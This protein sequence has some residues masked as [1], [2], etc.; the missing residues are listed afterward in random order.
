ML[1][2]VEDL[3]VGDEIIVPSGSSL[4]YYKI[5]RTPKLSKSQPGYRNTVRY[6]AVRCST[7]TK[8][9]TKTSVYGTNTYT[10]TYTE[11]ECTPF[12]HNTEKSVDLNYKSIWLVKEGKR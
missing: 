9:T 4:R 5:L 8:T 12:E 10:N 2:K 6:A 1:V 7:K 11:Y 3:I